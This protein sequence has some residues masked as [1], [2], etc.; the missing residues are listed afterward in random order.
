LSIEVRTQIPILNAI[1]RFFR[2]N[3]LGSYYD[4]LSKLG[5]CAREKPSR[6][7]SAAV[8]AMDI[9]GMVL[10]DYKKARACHLTLFGSTNAPDDLW[11]HP[12]LSVKLVMRDGTHKAQQIRGVTLWLG[13]RTHS[14]KA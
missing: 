9:H 2:S 11:T 14:T 7:L 10:M 8:G 12:W 1:N 6:C 3:Y 4:F 5:K 13:V